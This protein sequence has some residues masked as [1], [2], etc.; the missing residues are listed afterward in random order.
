ME[1]SEHICG[2]LQGDGPTLPRLRTAAKSSDKPHGNVGITPD[3]T[4]KTRPIQPVMNNPISA[5]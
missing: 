1:V 2:C 4:P 5:V 3:R